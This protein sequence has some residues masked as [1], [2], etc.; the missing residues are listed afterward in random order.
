MNCVESV[1]VLIPWPRKSVATASVEARTR[2]LRGDILAD[3][4]VKDKSPGERDAD[5]LWIGEPVAAVCVT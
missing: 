5:S 1:G 2:C 4:G 3:E